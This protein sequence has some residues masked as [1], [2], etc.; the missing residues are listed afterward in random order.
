MT[1]Q[2]L[3][4]YS[5][6]SAWPCR[7]LHAAACV[8]CYHTPITTPYYRDGVSRVHLFPDC[9]ATVSHAH[10]APKTSGAAHGY[11]QQRKVQLHSCDVQIMRSR[12]AGVWEL[13]VHQ[14]SFKRG[15]TF[16]GFRDGFDAAT[17]ITIQGLQL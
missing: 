8:R 7:S 12:D 13:S 15:G 2:P 17:P 9:R 3:Q 5:L 16:T 11:R 10:D 4:M 1:T 6:Q 14:W